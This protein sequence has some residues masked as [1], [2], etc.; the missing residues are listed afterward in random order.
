MPCALNGSG[1]GW[2]A[3]LPSRRR[4]WWRLRLRVWV[5][6]SLVCQQNATLRLVMPSKDDNNNPFI[7]RTI[8]LSII[9]TSF[10]K[11]HTN[12]REIGYRLASDWISTIKVALNITI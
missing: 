6:L 4:I 7:R 11:A 9:L 12:R 2:L 8:T 5:G 1:F 10:L 3:W